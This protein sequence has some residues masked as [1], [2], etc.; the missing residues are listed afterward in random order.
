MTAAAVMERILPNIPFIRGITVSGGECTL[1]PPFLTELFTLAHASRLTCLI[2]SNGMTSFAAH[3]ELMNVTDGVMLDVKAW[4][5]TV[6]RALTGCAGHSILKANL[7]YLNQH[8]K[9]SELRIVYLPGMVDAADA[10]R[11]TTNILGENVGKTSLKLIA[12]RNVGVREPYASAPSP[13]AEEMQ[14]L[15]ETAWNEGFRIVSIV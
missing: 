13:S 12:F 6:F 15:S 1:Y 14:A 2:D 11:G 7:D 10:I 9:I 3:E 4:N 8:N 5:P